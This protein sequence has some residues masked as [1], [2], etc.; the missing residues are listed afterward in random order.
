M[1]NKKFLFLVM[2]MLLIFVPACSYSN[3]YYYDGDVIVVLKPSASVSDSSVS[4]SDL[5]SINAS[6]F[7]ASSGTFVKAIYPSLSRIS[8]ND[9]VLLHSDS[10]DPEELTKELLNDSNVLAASPNY[11]VYASVVPN[12]T[13]INECWGLVG[14]DGI[15][16]SQA[17]ETTKGSSD[18]YVA[19]IDSGI[20]YTQPEL[21]GNL[22]TSLSRNIINGSSYSAT[23]YNGHGTHVAGIIGAKGNNNIGISGVNWN[24]KLIA[25]KALGDN[26]SGSVASVIS[27]LDYVA[28]LI[29]VQKVNIR[30][31]NMSLETYIKLVPNHDNLVQFPL[32]R[33]FKNIDVLNKAVIVVAAGN[34]SEIVGE[35]STTAHQIVPGAGYYVYPASFKGL[36][37]MISVGALQSD[38]TLANFSNKNADIIAP[39]VKI[40]S[41]WLSSSSN[42]YSKNDGVSLA[43]ESGTSMA[44]PF[45]SGAVGLLAS[46]APDDVTAYQLRTALTS[47]VSNSSVQSSSVKLNQLFKTLNNYIKNK[48]NTEMFPANPPSSSYDDYI[49]YEPDTTNVEYYSDN[50]SGGGGGCNTNIF[51][52]AMLVGISLLPLV[53]KLMS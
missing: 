45:V 10:K 1:L 27:A 16:A 50:D 35:P 6:N 9:Y 46:V 51:A 36:D 22:D 47:D 11:K 23:D 38:G 20:D 14:E 48:D 24:V 15:G 41:T 18:V 33:A 42:E 5:T 49:S 26:G 29:S 31:V 2:T 25:V 3:E 44:A 17:W 43:L 34:Y 13:Y 19:V 12:D 7:A 30:A 52:G 4:A 28:D 8:N 53:K 37:N 40:L 39:G 32:W 21:K